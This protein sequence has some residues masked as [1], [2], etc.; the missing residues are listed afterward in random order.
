[1]KATLK[2]I[3][4]FCEASG[5]TFTKVENRYRRKGEMAW[6]VEGAHNERYI[7][8]EDYAQM[9]QAGRDR[10]NALRA[11]SVAGKLSGRL[12]DRTQEAWE[13]AIIGCLRDYRNDPVALESIP[14]K[15]AEA[16][17][18]RGQR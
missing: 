16:A 5:L 6:Y 9:T 3:Q 10:H 2:T 11:V 13:A 14:A 15:A 1:M 12:S 8:E 4:A 17:R 7:P 18:L